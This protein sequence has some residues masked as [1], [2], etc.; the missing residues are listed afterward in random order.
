MAG[1]E[2]SKRR[3]LR[4]REDRKV[5]SPSEIS[6]PCPARPFI[7]RPLSD[8]RTCTWSGELPGF[9]PPAAPHGAPPG[10]RQD[11]WCVTWFLAMA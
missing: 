3:E 8:I 10:C 5:A 7:T 1:G 11:I 4:W 2:V 6:A 9:L